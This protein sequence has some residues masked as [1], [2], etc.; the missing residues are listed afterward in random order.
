MPVNAIDTFT[1]LGLST[2]NSE[3]KEKKSLGQE[4]FLEL[5]TTQL[6]HQDPLKPMENGDFLGQMAQFSTVS[7]IQDLQKSFADFASSLS[8]DQALKAT[9]LIGHH[10]NA[11][12]DSGLLETGGVIK[13][14]FDLPDSS[15]NVNVKIIDPKT[16]EV[17]KN[18]KLGNQASGKIPFEWDGLDE[19]GNL[20]VPGVYKI[21]VEAKIDGKNTVLESRVNSIVES[22]SLGNGKKGIQL[23][24]KGLGTIDFKQVKQ[25]L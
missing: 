4:Q 25:I 3:T 24:L 2:T 23:K 12:S 22:V 8:S 14:D 20:S 19:D 16:G 9:S 13:G 5:L 1:E 17:V 11:P 15:P 7:G 6:T 10:V 18:I 21:Q